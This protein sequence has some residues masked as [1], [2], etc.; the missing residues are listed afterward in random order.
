MKY[1]LCVWY[2]TVRLREPVLF[3]IF[4]MYTVWDRSALGAGFVLSKIFI[5]YAVRNHLAPGT[6]FL[7]GTNYFR[8]YGP[9]PF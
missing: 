2:G 3:K 9:G 7:Y 6:G 8:S 4:I 5:V 1:S